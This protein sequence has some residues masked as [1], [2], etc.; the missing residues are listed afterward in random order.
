MWLLAPTQLPVGLPLGA[1]L[2]PGAGQ[3]ATSCDYRR[4]GRSVWATAT[5]AQTKYCISHS[6]RSVMLAQHAAWKGRQ[7]QHASL[8]GG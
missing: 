5:A 4:V 7:Q 3:A 6:S 2:M 8:Q 1:I